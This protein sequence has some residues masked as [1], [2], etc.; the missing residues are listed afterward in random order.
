MS[1]TEYSQDN[2]AAIR[3]RLDNLE[4]MTRLSIA[5]NPNSGLHIEELFRQPA[6]SADLYLA[7]ESGPKTQE[8][9]A[10]VLRKSRA[11]VSRVLTHLHESG[12]IDRLTGPG[13]VLWMWHDMERALGISRVA[14]RLA[15][16]KP[17][18]ETGSS[19]PDATALPTD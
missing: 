15:S 12:L 4:K 18:T 6:G 8:N 17:T 3:T 19:E 2:I 10:D 5:A 16:I 13:G 14:K 9:L 1:E 11:T 7:L